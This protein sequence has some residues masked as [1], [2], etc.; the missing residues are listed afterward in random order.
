VNYLYYIFGLGSIRS[1]GSRAFGLWS[2]CFV[3]ISDSRGLGI[4]GG[5]G[6]CE[7]KG[8]NKG[9]SGRTIITIFRLS[10]CRFSPYIITRFFLAILA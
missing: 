4:N 9:E 5:E 8:E 2:K 3:N 10:F 7:N 6:S 1:G